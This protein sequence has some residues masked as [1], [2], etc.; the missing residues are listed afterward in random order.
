MTRYIHRKNILFKNKIACMDKSKLLCVAIDPS[1]NVHRVIICDFQGKFVVKPFSIDALRNGFNNLTEM[2]KK[3]Y[4]KISAQEIYIAIETPASYSTNLIYALKQEYGKVYFIAPNAVAANRKQKLLSALKTDDIDAASVADL[5][6]RGE[7]NEYQYIFDKYYELRELTIWHQKKIKM[8]TSLRNQVVFR[9]DKTYPGLNTGYGE[10][11]L[12]AKDQ[13]RAKIYQ[14]LI[15]NCMTIDELLS[16]DD[17]ELA[18]R[19]GYRYH[20]KKYINRLKTR[21]MELLPCDEGITS[22]QIELL[23]KDAKLLTNLNEEIK[24]V[25]EKIEVL[26]DSTP[27]LNLCQVK[28]ISKLYAGMYQG[29]VGNIK[30]Y[31]S[32][33]QVYAKAGLNPIISQSGNKKI[34]RYKI[35]KAGSPTLRSILYTMVNNVILHNKVFKNYNNK[36]KKNRNM[37]WKKRRIALTNKLNRLMFAL[38]RDQSKY[39]ENKIEPL[40]SRN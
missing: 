22:L 37:H 17:I 20:G 12:L 4:K 36:L 16:M 39:V 3:A 38:M 29:L 25:E 6:I 19:F 33:S 24:T 23:R 21:L 8:R 11:K 26:C 7:F 32:A 28:G 18:K 5:L 15:N 1:K 30:K 14:G 34:L 13:S 2:V 31:K 27:A 10:N 40:A 9:M 35:S